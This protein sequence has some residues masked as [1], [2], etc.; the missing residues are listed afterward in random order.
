MD[1]AGAGG[2]WKTINELKDST[3]IQQIN[4]VSCGAACGEMLFKNKGFDIEQ[5]QLLA[6][7]GSPTWSEQ[8]AYA[9]NQF[10]PSEDGEWKGGY[11]KIIGA[12]SKQVFLSLCTTG[13]WIAELRE[14]LTKMGHFV[15][16]DGIDEQEKPIIR[17]P[18]DRTRYKMDTEEFLKY[19]SQQGVFWKQR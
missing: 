16:V 6:L 2:K 4:D 7:A 11:F 18:W 8:L 12:T 1:L 3:V 19:W 10:I 13:S 15:V 5:E 9:M 17:D 14:P